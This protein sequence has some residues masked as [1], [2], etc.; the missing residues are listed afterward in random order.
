MS[1]TYSAQLIREMEENLS[2]S[3]DEV[4]TVQQIEVE[5]EIIPGLRENSRL[6]WEFR[7]Q[8]L[9]YRNVYSKKTGNEACK[10]YKPG[11]SVRLYIR[12]DG[13]AFRYSNLSHAKIH[14][15][16]YKER[17]EMY[18]FNKMKDRAKTAPP[19]VTVFQIYQEAVQE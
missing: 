14:G 9:Y 17:K 12:Q 2:E 19:S 16:M 6:V 7:E 13:S 1:D 3:D 5:Y 11:C 15:S 8:N 4:I 10:C 18:C